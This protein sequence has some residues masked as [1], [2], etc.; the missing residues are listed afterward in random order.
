LVAL[1]VNSVREQFDKMHEKLRADASARGSCRVVTQVPFDMSASPEEMTGIYAQ[2]WE[3]LA[4][5]GLQPGIFTTDDPPPALGRTYPP[6]Q[7]VHYIFAC[8]NGEAPEQF[9]PLAQ[10]LRCLRN[11]AAWRAFGEKLPVVQARIESARARGLEEVVV[12]RFSGLDRP[13]PIFPF[14]GSE[15]TLPELG[16]L[17]WRYLMEHGINPVYGGRPASYIN[18]PGLGRL[19][20][21]HDARIYTLSAGL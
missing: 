6:D 7:P 17:T 8:W 20:F 16:Q 19:S 1:I 11:A 5:E 14:D 21:V 3:H 2:I 13:T 9:R 4:A 18:V 15:T 12:F 10:E